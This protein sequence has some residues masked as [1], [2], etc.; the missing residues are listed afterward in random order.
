M[1]CERVP[2]AKFDEVSVFR[3]P[4]GSKDCVVVGNNQIQGNAQLR[5][6]SSVF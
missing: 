6:E 1:T 2:G 3:G 5:E 4:V